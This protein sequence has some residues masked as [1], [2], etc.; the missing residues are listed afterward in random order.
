M[1]A[2]ISEENN[3]NGKRVTVVGAGVSGKGLALLASRL[4]ASVFV[5]EQKD[6]PQETEAEFRKLG[7]EFESGG[8]TPRAFEADVILLSSGVPPHAPVVKEAERRGIPMTGE[9]DFVVPHI[10]GRIIAVTGCNGKS[11]VTALTGHM[12]RR[13]SL[14]TATGGNLGTAAADFADGNFDAVVLELSSF[15]LARASRLSSCLSIVTNLAPDHIDWHG[16]Y[17]AY[18]AAKARAIELRA[19]DGW[20]IVQ[21]RD[22]DALGAA[23][24]GRIVTLSWS[25]EPRHVMAGHI[26]MGDDRAVLI[27]DGEEIPLFLYSDTSLLGKHNLENAAMSSAALRLLGVGTRSAELMD[28][29]VPLPHRCANAGTIDG[30]LYV[31]DSKG[32]N[33][34]ASS[35]AMT[36]IGGRKVVILGGQG[37]G[38]DY[39]PLAEVTAREAD[40]A[41]LLGEER[42][43]IASALRNAGFTAFHIVSDMEEAVRK[44]HSLARPGM[45]VLLS[46]ACTSWD[47]Y[48]SYNHRG[49]HFCSLVKAL[50]VNA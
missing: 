6:I 28:D 43:A 14:N 20:G 17:E 11:T 29:F 7:I 47:M 3:W 5:T 8:N 41:V 36:S 31:D 45:T 16:S 48:K 12:M 13:A 30:V 27:R 10:R 50:Q 49:E 40:F 9:T 22:V 35:A 33:V 18:V 26:F 15:Q 23:S 19:A 34:A 21:D 25:R 39:A 42:E 44:A 2:N 4:G 37:K 38:E 24:A 1:C 46:P 32:T